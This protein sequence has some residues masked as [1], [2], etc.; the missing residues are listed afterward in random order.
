[1][2]FWRGQTVRRR[3]KIAGFSLLEMLFATLILLVGLVGIAQ[4]V[5]ATIL[6]DHKSRLN[7]TLLVLAQRELDQMLQQSLAVPSF[8]DADGNA[9]N[10][11]DPTTPDTPVGNALLTGPSG[12]PVID[13]SGTPL[14]GYNFQYTDPN[15]PSGVSYDVRWTVI[16]H[17]NGSAITSKRIILGVRQ[18]GGGF[19]PPVTLD[20]MVQK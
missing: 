4:L 7:S 20:T 10:L 2:R 6:F 15:D 16:T 14:S 18:V 19:V 13:F 9:C 5:P 17:L 11:G 1:M 8:L 12:E 3:R